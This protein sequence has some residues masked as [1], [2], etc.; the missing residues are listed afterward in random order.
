MVIP[1]EASII[2]RFLTSFSLLPF[3]ENPPG[4]LGRQAFAERNHQLIEQSGGDIGHA[5]TAMDQL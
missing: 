1:G 2:H 5:G 3:V 4:N